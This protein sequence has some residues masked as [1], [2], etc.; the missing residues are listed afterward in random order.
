MQ[1]PEAGLRLAGVPALAPND[2]CQ[3][4]GDLGDELVVGATGRG[5]RRL[6]GGQHCTRPAVQTDA[7]AR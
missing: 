7:L 4:V 2:R 3:L 5:R 6:H 1:A